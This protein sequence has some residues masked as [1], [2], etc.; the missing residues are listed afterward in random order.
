MYAD[1]WS[2]DSS[3]Y[4]PDALRIVNRDETQEK[5]TETWAP[6]IVVQA[7]FESI[8]KCIVNRHDVTLPFSHVAF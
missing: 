2:Q 4:Y 5:W 6:N 7:K 1:T 3:R 8:G